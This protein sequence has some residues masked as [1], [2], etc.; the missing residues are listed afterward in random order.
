MSETPSFDA[1]ADLP[2]P[3]KNSEVAKDV[4]A[5]ATDGGVL[6]YGV[7]EDAD[8]NPTIPQ[9]I[10]LAG[11][12]DRIS[13]IVAT[14]IAEVPFIDVRSLPCENEP[15]QGYLVV[16]VPQSARAPHM[17][18]VGGE[19]R[20]YGRSATGNRI[21]SE[22]DVARLYE[23]RST[24]EINREELLAQVI[25]HAPLPRRADRGYVHAYTRPVAPS[26]DMLERAQA[27]LDGEDMLGWLLNTARTTT[28]RGQYGPS[29][30]RTPFLRRH[31]GD[32]WR[33][34]TLGEEEIAATAAQSADEQRDPSDLV[35]IDL[36]I[37]GRGQL[38]CGRATDAVRGKPDERLLFEIVIAGNVETFLAVMGALYDA[39]GY[40][41]AVDVGLAITGVQGAHSERRER[42]FGGP[43]YPVSNYTRTIRVAAAQLR[44]AGEIAQGLL[45]H[46]FEATTG[47]D[48][49]NP[50]TQPSHR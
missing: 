48:G 19:N 43:P 2:Q 22:G 15:S 42:S 13:Q 12:A 39:A 11:A 24:W 50:W 16:I 37:D 44:D 35:S 28:L 41:G 29:L 49:Y 1:K 10:E 30:E 47:I 4:G 33:W 3:K 7:A 14:S 31:G 21:L 25:A 34:A 23:R 6:L 5:M 46:F 40:H 45:R 20:Y 36:N 17:V 27:T 8:G 26:Q 32:M 18:V 38:F 9:P